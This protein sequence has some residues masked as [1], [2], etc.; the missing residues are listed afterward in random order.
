MYYCVEGVTGFSSRAFKASLLRAWVVLVVVSAGVLAGCE[1][2]GTNTT[3]PNTNGVTTTTTV[4]GTGT[5]TITPPPLPPIE[6]IRLGGVVYVRVP[7]TTATGVI[8][9]NTYKNFD[10]YDRLLETVTPEST[11]GVSELNGPGQLVY[12]DA[13]GNTHILYDCMN[14]VPACVPLDP[15]VDWA[16]G[17]VIFSVYTGVLSNLQMH[18]TTLPN[19]TM[20]ST[21]AQIHIVD[22]QTKQVTPLPQPSGVHDT[23]PIWLSD[24]RIMFTSTRSKEHGIMLRGITPQHHYQL[25]MWMMDA[26]GSN[27]VRVGPSDINSALHPYLLSSGRVIYSSWQLNHQLA[28][29]GGP[30]NAPGTTHNM[31]WVAS[32]DQRGGDWLSLL[33]AH[34][35]FLPTNGGDSPKALHFLGERSNGDICTTNYYRNNNLGSGSFVCWKPEA[36]GVEGYGPAEVTEQR[37]VFSPR[38]LYL[39]IPYTTSSDEESLKDS[40][41]NYLGKVRDPDGLPNGNLLFSYGRGRCSQAHLEVFDV[42]SDNT[43]CD[44]G[45]YVTDAQNAETATVLSSDPTDL[46]LVADSSDWH[47]FMPRIVAPYVDIYKKQRPDTPA[48]TSSGDPGTC[49]LGSSSMQVHGA[50]GGS[51]P[52][53]SEIQHFNGWEFGRKEICG[54]QGCSMH[55]VDAVSEISKIRFWRVLPYSRPEGQ[56]VQHNEVESIFGTRVQILGD[57]PLQS[58]GS[59]LTQLPCDMP[60][61]M[62]GVDNDGRVIAKDQVV[63]SLRPGEKRICQGCHVH[64][65]DLGLDFNNRLAASNPATVLPSSG[66]EP[67]FNR[68]IWPLLQS[69]CASCHSSGSPAGGL[70]LDVPGNGASS[71]YFKITW[72]H[73]N[74]VLRP[75]TSRYMHGVFARESLLYWKA[76]GLRTDGR[77]DADYSGDIDFGAAHAGYLTANEL[78]LLG[79]WMESGAY[80]E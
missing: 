1:S 80:Y 25:Q 46:K 15:M 61:L 75:E 43:V 16:G 79:D 60:Y 59:F 18:G 30:G 62:A 28:F 51:K 44:F 58:D 52:S 24:G 63:Q 56:T 71:T 40:G 72:D 21:G 47:E 41:G 68:D 73:A 6:P 3:D 55:A 76:A 69:N 36:H 66:F 42:Q 38:N 9:G 31:F 57:V 14:S 13:D 27:A 5:G 35:G 54:S 12:L 8:N 74:T 26:D 48:L 33:G 49:L 19:R 37:A 11:L 34:G 10:V 78:K 53:I 20:Q 77:N 4:P 50:T 65:V 39:P 70:A 64:S 22:L 45:I 29:R 2:S 32:I 7:R 67:E 23:G 17:K